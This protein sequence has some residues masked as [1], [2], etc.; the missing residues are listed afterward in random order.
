MPRFGW[1]CGLGNK[2]GVC[3]G[4]RENRL[5]TKPKIMSSGVRRFA[6]VPQT[7]VLGPPNRRMLRNPG[8]LSSPALGIFCL[9]LA[10]DRL[11]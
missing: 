9:W 10:H 11:A 8:G 6:K 3:D 1:C 2:A 5:S 7:V 4:T